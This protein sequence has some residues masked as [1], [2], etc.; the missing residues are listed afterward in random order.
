MLALIN[1][2]LFLK[3]LN[4]LAVANFMI[5]PAVADALNQMPLPQRTHMFPLTAAGAMQTA[6][7]ELS[8][9]IPE[10]QAYGLKV[11]LPNPLGAVGSKGKASL[12]IECENER[13]RG[14]RSRQIKNITDGCS[15]YKIFSS[16]P[17][18]VEIPYQPEGF[19]DEIDEAAVK[20]FR[21]DDEKVASIGGVLPLDSFV[22]KQNKRTVATLNEQSGRY[23]AGV[24]KSV[25]RPDRVPLDFRG[26]VLADLNHANPVAGVPIVPKPEANSN[27]DANI[28]Y[29]LEFPAVRNGFA[30]SISLGYVSRSGYSSLGEGWHLSIPEIAVET[31]WGPPIYDNDYETETYLFNGEQLV[32]EAGTDFGADPTDNLHLVQMPHRTSS[33]RRRTKGEA[34]F[35]LRRDDG[36]WRFIRHGYLPDDYWWEAWQERP[37]SG[38]PK[39]MYFGAAPGRLP[40]LI[41]RVASNDIAGVAQTSRF[42]LPVGPVTTN[43]R[44]KS[45]SRWVLGRE[46]DVHQNVIDYDWH[47]DCQ[48]DAPLPTRGTIEGDCASSV[49]NTVRSNNLI[50]R[51][52]IYTSNKAMEETIRRCEEEPGNNSACRRDIALYEAL[53][54]WSPVDPAYRRSDARS[55]GLIVN[56]RRLERI[57]VRARQLKTK[58]LGKMPLEWSCSKPF[59]R[60]AF[61]YRGEFDVEADPSERGTGRAFLKSITKKVGGRPDLFQPIDNVPEASCDAPGPDGFAPES[62]LSFVTRFD[63]DLANERNWEETTAEVDFPRLQMLPLV[64]RV[65]DALMGGEQQLGPVAPSM[66]GTTATTDTSTSFYAGL[67]FFNAGKINS[68]GVESHSSNRTGYREATLLLDVDGDGISDFLTKSSDQSAYQVFRGWLD[69]S[70]TLH[71]AAPVQLATPFPGFSNEPSQSTTGTAVE[72]FLLG[73]FFGSSSTNASSMQDSYIAD[74]NSDGKP[75]VV[76]NRVVYFNTSRDG[77]FSFSTTQRGEFIDPFNA[78][79][80]PL[81]ATPTL[82]TDLRTAVPERSNSEDFPRED[83]VRVWRAPFSGDVFVGGAVIYDPPDLPSDHQEGSVQMDHRDGAIFTIELNHHRN[84]DQPGRLSRCFATKFDK[85][86][87]GAPPQKVNF[88]TPGAGNQTPVPVASCFEASR[89]GWPDLASLPPGLTGDKGLLV[90]VEAGD[91]LYFRVHAIDNA[92]DDVI[93]LDFSVDYLRLAEDR[94]ALPGTDS[95]QRGIVYGLGLASPS[96]GP[97]AILSSLALGSSKCAQLVVDDAQG[98][99]QQID[100]KNLGLCDPWGRSI[101]RYRSNDE[102]DLFA[103]GAGMLIAPYTGRMH[104]SGKLS[105]ADTLFPG[106]IAIRILPPPENPGAGGAAPPSCRSAEWEVARTTFKSILRFGREAGAYSVIDPIAPDSAL[107]V[108]RGDRICVFFRFWSTEAPLTGEQIKAVIWPDD[109]SKFSWTND[110]LKAVFDRKL[111]LVHLD[112]QDASADEV[113][114][115]LPPLDRSAPQ[116]PD[117]QCPAFDASPV[118]LRYPTGD[119]DPRLPQGDPNPANPKA[120]WHGVKTLYVYAKCAELPGRGDEHWVAPRAL[121]SNAPYFFPSLTNGPHP[122]ARPLARKL[123]TIKLPPSGLTCSDN[124]SLKEYRF[125]MDVGALEE[126]TPSQVDKD[127]QKSKAYDEASPGA[128]GRMPIA[129]HHLVLALNRNG[130]REPL[131]VRKFV[132]LEAGKTEPSRID[133]SILLDDFSNG[134][135]SKVDDISVPLTI[136]TEVFRY[137]PPQEA[138]P[139]PDLTHEALYSELAHTASD[140]HVYPI[141]RIGY[142]FCAPDESEIDVA[143]SIENLVTINDRGGELTDLRGD[144]ILSSGFCGP[145]ESR[146]RSAC[147]LVMSSVRLARDAGAGP[148]GS[149][150]DLPLF[151]YRRLPID[152]ESYRGWSS[153]GVTTEFGEA[154]AVD[155]GMV[156]E[157]VLS[158]LGSDGAP[159]ADQPEKLPTVRDFNRLR[160]RLA[161]RRATG[162]NDPTAAAGALQNGPCAGAQSTSK[163]VREKFLSQIRVHPLTGSFR[164]Q[165]NQR[166][167]EWA[168]C[169][170][171]G[172][173]RQRFVTEQ[174]SN[175]PPTT[176]SR[177][178]DARIGLNINSAKY[179]EIGPDAGVWSSGDYLS[180]SRLGAKDLINPVSEALS[181]QAIL[182]AAAQTDLDDRLVRLMPRVSQTHTE[183]SAASGWLGVAQTTVTTTS[184]ADI[185]DLNGDGFPDQI[186]G[187]QAYL[188]DP[189]GALRCLT[190]G[191][192]SGRFPCNTATRSD[193]A[194]SFGAAF[195]RKSKGET[196][197]LSIPFLSPKTFAQGAASAAGRIGA[198]AKSGSAVQSDFTAK[199][200]LTSLSLGAEFTRGKSEKDFDLTDLNGDGL[201]DL[202]ASTSRKATSVTL[203]SGYQLFGDVITSWDDSLSQEESNAAGLSAALGYG[204]DIYE[205]GG[206]LSASSSRSRQ[207]RVLADINGDGLTDVAWAQDG[208]V[209]ARLNTGFGFAGERRF[210]RLNQPLDAFGQGESD[211]LAAN[212]Y[213]TFSIPIPLPGWLFYIIL[214]PGASLGA[215]LNRQVVAFRDINGDGL[216]DLVATGGLNVGGV[217]NMMFDNHKARVHKNPLT[218]HGLLTAVYLPTN[219]ESRSATGEAEKSNYQ[220]SYARSAPTLND[221]Q[222]R[223]VL[224]EVVVRDGVTLDDVGGADLHRTCHSYGG[225]FFDRFERRFLGFSKVVTVEGCA[226]AFN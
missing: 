207:T 98:N 90:S 70:G 101:V 83:T 223:M 203:N 119:D 179:C 161:E 226:T 25:E 192:W 225:A 133:E 68:F 148:V 44:P 37:T 165:T 87:A 34:L 215:A 79:G 59:L 153:V 55:G 61:A 86:L 168:Y 92:Q 135:R 3:M 93:K 188:T 138:R 54:S 170:D 187:H 114:K 105:K 72:A 7:L 71:F 33:L 74:V 112:H 10:S 143:S 182:D 132:V 180:A 166:P 120:P 199:P 147:P 136:S 162:F 89:A 197:T 9:Q 139:D 39:V 218:T 194:T 64:D 113:S 122:K 69:S 26:Q 85:R 206:G 12:F 31:R 186:S 121:G 13:D 99:P 145:A 184:G 42:Q 152:P 156:L 60:Y 144:K 27:G 171:N 78:A 205:Y 58:Y 62:S 108:K 73:T 77:Q 80:L 29:P 172:R 67:N 118:T 107:F 103:N 17:V 117:D 23:I 128:L 141:D 163:C 127:T 124:A 100:E 102:R 38:A 185:F 213:A 1:R 164:S 131:R 32:P 178:L 159:T 21:Q 88:Q 6:A 129:N 115:I 193:H 116:K 63:Y 97:K 150:F 56:S 140:V 106:E 217:L 146:G 158:P 41:E 177:S 167:T 151:G 169:N 35:V 214:N 36:L 96:P 142:S 181:L 47:L 211:M 137:I 195:S 160:I 5:T 76:S 18:T 130:R 28:S 40:D 50:L 75:D 94:P 125:R 200:A 219:P 175:E 204:N 65:R 224:S 57:D 212:A 2:Q 20:V 51:R 45:I 66:L 104:F 81:S 209:H 82:L 109:L 22:D 15:A 134:A 191:V 216:G 183:G 220:L 157:N 48:S 190:S 196:N 24:L 126:P 4:I 208:V 176:E 91:I 11:K 189:G 173:N 46:V 155:D 222:S 123:S 8:Q 30:P 19:Q 49:S 202:V 110:G 174:E 16:A 95:I 201:P 221:P 53:L 43:P 210:G 52:I 14:K 198:A 84:W 149:S 111:L 154:P